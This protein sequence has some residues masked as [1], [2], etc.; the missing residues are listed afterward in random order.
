[1]QEN[2]IIYILRFATDW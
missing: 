1:M 2:V